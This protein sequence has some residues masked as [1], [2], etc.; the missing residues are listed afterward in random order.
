LRALYS[1]VGTISTGAPHYRHLADLYYLDGDF[2]DRCL[3]AVQAQ[4]LA[5]SELTLALI[6]KLEGRPLRKDDRASDE[7][8]Q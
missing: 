8:A 6:A 7:A 5:A 1:A 2:S 3:Q 4:Q